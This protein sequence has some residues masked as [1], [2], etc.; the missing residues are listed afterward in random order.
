MTTL[1]LSDIHVSDEC[2][3]ISEHLEEFLLEEGSKADTIFVLGDL[4]E[5]WLGDDDPNP[6]F[7]EIKQLFKKLSDKNI[8][9]FFIHGNRDFLI[10]KSFAKQLVSIA[11]CLPAQLLCNWY[12]FRPD[13]KSFS[14]DFLCKG[15]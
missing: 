1:F 12:G 5:Y 14:D 4:F 15:L 10:G 3:E 13:K 8:S 11:K 2:P 9:I 6:L 7:K